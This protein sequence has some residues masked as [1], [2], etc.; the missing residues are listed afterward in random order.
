MK[1]NY[2]GSLLIAFAIGLMI[3]FA[4]AHACESYPFLA[5]WV[6]GECWFEDGDDF[7]EDAEQV[8]SA[9]KAQ[10]LFLQTTV[11]R[12]G[13]TDD[14]VLKAAIY[15]LA[16]TGSAEAISTLKEIVRTHPSIEIRK[17]GLY[18]L[19]QCADAREQVV[20]FSDIIENN[21]MMELR[22]AA[23]Y[24]LGQ[25]ND[26]L[27]VKVLEEVA[28][29]PYHVELRKAAVYALQNNQSTEAQQALYR[30]LAKTSEA[31]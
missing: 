20:F 30:I 25:V 29:T 31:L 3:F 23:L 19:A 28:T 27:V 12:A 22:K 21:D 4:G 10:A 18:A 7:A 6:G 15:A 8:P 13:D 17:A 5:K 26:D 16:Q 14:E 2:V 1:N 24:A 9:S 11:L